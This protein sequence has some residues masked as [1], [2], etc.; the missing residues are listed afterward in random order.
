MPLISAAKL[1]GIMSR[2]GLM[3][4]ACAMRSATGMKIAVTAVELMVA[5]SPQTTDHKQDDEANLAVSGLGDQPVAQPL[6][7]PRAHQAIADDEKRCDQDDVRIAEAGQRLVHGEHAREG[8]R[9]EHDQRD[10]VQARL[11]DREHHDRGSKQDQDNPETRGHFILTRHVLSAV[12]HSRRMRPSPLA[13]S[14]ICCEADTHADIDCRKCVDPQFVAVRLRASKRTD[15][16]PAA[17]TNISQQAV[18]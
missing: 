16:C 11:V 5:P 1:S 18:P 15:P 7:H 2:P 17:A 3:P 14:G 6:G 9:H 13:C 10:G 4:V 8:Q 12:R